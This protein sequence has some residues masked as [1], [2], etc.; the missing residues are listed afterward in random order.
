[1]LKAEAEKAVP[2]GLCRLDLF[3]P[4]M[5]FSST[6][7]GGVTPLRVRAKPVRGLAK[8]RRLSSLS[9]KRQGGSF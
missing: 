9:S 7:V 1:M 2:F 6:A 4:D 8:M 3:V 5:K